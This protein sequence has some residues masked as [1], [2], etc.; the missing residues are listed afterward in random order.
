LTDGGLKYAGFVEQELKAERDRRTS[1]DARAQSLVTTSGSLVTLL[2][3]VGAFVSSRSGY[4]LPRGA[5]YPLVVTV[6]MFTITLLFAI[7][8]TYNFKYEVADAETLLQIPRSHWADSEDIA[9]KNITATNVTTVLTLRRGNDRKVKF[10]LAALVAQLV[11][12]GSLGATVY[13]MIIGV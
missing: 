8:A 4:A 10:I 7:V 6:T 5:G 1:L 12:L 9:V 2:S 3:A 11:A 13:L